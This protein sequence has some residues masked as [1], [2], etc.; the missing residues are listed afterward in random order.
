[1]ALCWTRAFVKDLA[2]HPEARG[3]G[4]AEALMWH[5]FTT[6]HA[7]GAAHVDLK[8]NTVEKAAAVRL[9]ERLGMFEVDWAG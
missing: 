5:V 7:R 3:R 2:V 9:Y 6:F 8:T 4:I 1:A